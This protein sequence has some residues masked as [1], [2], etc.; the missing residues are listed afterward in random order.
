MRFEVVNGT[1]YARFERLLDTPG[2][3]H[4]FST[5]GF[6]VSAR[7]DTRAA[8]RAARR[9]RMAHDW[10]LEPPLLCHCVQTH[11]GHITVVREPAGARLE[12]YDAVI[13]DRP[14]VSLMTFSADCPLVLVY[15]PTRRALGLAHAS[16]RCTVACIVKRLIDAL[17]DNY[18]CK[19][20]HLVAG[21]GPSA[22]PA[23]Y[24]VKDDVYQ[25]AATL[26]RHDRFFPRRD[27]RMYFDLWAANRDQLLRS[28]VPAENI[29]IAG[30][31]TMAQTDLFY[32][33]RR[34]GAGCGHF[35]LLAAIAPADTRT[36]QS[37]VEPR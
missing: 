19:P 24:E 2:L 37:N 17:R 27:G 3:I 31:C 12:G 1:R 9:E 11:E 20:Q 26:D 34:E 30:V 16:W 28:G 18:G 33:F 35:G 4:A 21:I 25:A 36:T 6:D 8:E 15:D 32:S 7:E 23:A 29:E 5:R 14:G 13:T 10:G 22:G